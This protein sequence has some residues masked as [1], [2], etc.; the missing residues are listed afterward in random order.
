M[1]RLKNNEE[2][3]DETD[4]SPDRAPDTSNQLTLLL[5]LLL[6]KLLISDVNSNQ[7][8]RLISRQVCTYRTID[9]IKKQKQRR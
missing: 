7:T 6:S 5:L 3:S 2:G 4:V 1:V 9:A 8:C